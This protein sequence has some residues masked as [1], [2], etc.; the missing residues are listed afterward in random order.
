M[1]SLI[2]AIVAGAIGLG[3]AGAL[4]LIGLAEPARLT[5]LPI[6]VLPRQ[7]MRLR[8]FSYRSRGELP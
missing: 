2:V 6:R 1:L 7:S 5:S 3:L 4:K 8:H